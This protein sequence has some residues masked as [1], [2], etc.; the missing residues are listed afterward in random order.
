MYQ[1]HFGLSRPLFA[2]GVAQDEF[3]FRSAAAGAPRRPDRRMSRSDAVAILSGASGT[4]KTTL[5]TDA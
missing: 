1:R 2:D 4:G 5:A 3:V